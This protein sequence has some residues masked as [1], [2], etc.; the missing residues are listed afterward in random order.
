MS[1]NGTPQLEISPA[2]LGE[3]RRLVAAADGVEAPKVVRKRKVRRLP[4]FL[5]HGEFDALLDATPTP[6]DRMLVLL[7]RFAGLRVSE[8]TKL[9]IEHIDFAPEAAAGDAAV[10][11]AV[12]LIRVLEGK[13]GKDRNVPLHPKLAPSL[14]AWI[15][16][17][18]I[19]LLFESPR[20]AGSALTTRSVQRMIKAA[21]ISAGVTKTVT[22]HKMRHSF[23]TWMLRN[24]ANLRQVQK[25]LGH[26]NI[27]TTEIYTAVTD[28]ELDLVVPLA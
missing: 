22:P 18:R 1:G 3:L 11:T 19:G 20:K 24:G 5:T 16:A 25:V 15:G 23:A 28:E 8:A 27:G 17:R 6:R 14:R 10:K 2:L 9:R 26:A 7:M 4:V 13:G 12:G 21:G